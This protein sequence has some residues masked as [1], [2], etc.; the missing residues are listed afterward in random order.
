MNIPILR[1][2]FS[3]EDR[4]FIAGKI[5][6]VLDSG[7]LTMGRFTREFEARF[8]ELTGAAYA[9]ATSNGTTALE[10]IIRALGVQGKSIVVPTNTFLATAFAV[11]HSGNRVIFADSEP[12][13]L[14]LD[15]RDVAR[16]ITDDTAAVILVHIGGI[17]SPASDAIRSLCEAKK[18]YLIEDC[19]HSHG[20]TLRGRQSGTLGIAGAFSF[21]PTKVLVTGEGG[22]IT[23][24]DEGLYKEALMLRNH[25]KNPDL[26]NRMS[27]FGHNYRM[28]EITA[29]LGV[30]QMNKAREL[31]AERQAI[32]KAY[33]ERLRGVSG[34]MPVRLPDFVASSYYKYIA[35]LP[36]HHDRATVKRH[37]KERY[38]VS[39]TGEVY[40]DLCH[41]EPVWDKYSYCGQRRNREAVACHR[42]P[43]CGCDERQT[44]FPGAE[45]L[46]RSHVCLPVYPGL[47]SAEIDHVVASLDKTLN[48]DLGAGSTTRKGEN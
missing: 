42:W 5:A 6:E 30:N 40:A 39:L 20:S 31:I 34:I 3:G 32:A 15:P 14:C 4:A 18:I 19:A 41:T 9:V 35:Y 36:A 1:I 37:L 2:P 38:S 17:V 21:F 7:A 29:V 16:R 43:G 8:A 10:I 44:G 22:M 45:V 27:E 46:S 13:T 48:S 47:T 11:M 26:G 33:D 28:N 12:E 23:T 24:N 25:G